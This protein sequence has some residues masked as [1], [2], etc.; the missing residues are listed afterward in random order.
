MEA[1]N[2]YGGSS[3]LGIETNLEMKTLHLSECN[4]IFLIKYIPIPISSFVQLP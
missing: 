1:E 3:E 2:G 4:L